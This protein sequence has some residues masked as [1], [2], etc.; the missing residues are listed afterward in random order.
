MLTSEEGERIVRFI[1]GNRNRW[2]QLAALL[3]AQ[4]GTFLNGRCQLLHVGKLNEWWASVREEFAE[5]S[6]SMCTRSRQGIGPRTT[7][8]GAGGQVD[9]MHERDAKQASI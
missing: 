6:S 8:K 5:A 9:H 3:P 1:E 7:N 4:K 2:A